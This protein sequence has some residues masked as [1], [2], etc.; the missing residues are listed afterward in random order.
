M[1]LVSL[2]VRARNTLIHSC[3]RTVLGASTTQLFRNLSFTLNFSPGDEIVVSGIDHEANIAP[4]VDLAERQKLVLKWWLPSTKAQP[5]LTPENLKGR[6][7]EKTRLVT[8]THASN[9]LGTIHDIKAI[10]DLVHSQSPDALVC[11]DAVAYAPHRTIDVQA[12]GADA[13]AFSWYK[14]YG[15]HMSVL[16]ASS[17]ARKQMK[18]LGHFFNSH[19]SL[20]DKMGLAGSSYELVGSIPAVVKYLEGK[21]DGIVEHEHKLQSILLDYLNS[22]DDVTIHGETSSDPKVR[23]AT[24]SFTVEGWNS[25]ELV[26]LAEKDNSLGF[27]WGRFYSDRLVCEFLGLPKEGVVRVSMVHYNTSEYL[28]M[29]VSKFAFVW[30]TTNIV[31]DSEIEELIKVLDKVLSTKK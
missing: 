10:S 17:K 7:S 16:Y 21:G 20:E 9:I 4:W 14:V 18:S 1:T 11:V 26:E 24:V 6:L 12:L 29:S 31:V 5:K 8:L 27:R 13:Y 3:K 30:D 25:K 23:V 28:V 2:R 19:A 15:P 22:R